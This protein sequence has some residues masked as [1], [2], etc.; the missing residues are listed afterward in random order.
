MLRGVREFLTVVQAVVPVFLVVIGGWLIRRV[1]WL[2]GEADAS[3]LR[4]TVNVLMPCLVF[5][6]I[7]GSRAFAHAGQVLFAV[8]TGFA[9]VL[10]GL[11]V[12]LLVQ[13]WV[14]AR[15]PSTR[16]TFAF[17]VAIY[18]YGYLPLPLALALFDRETVAVL[19][20]YNVG[21]EI[22]FWSFALLLLAG[23]GLR[24]NWRRFLNPP[25]LTIVGT[26]TLNAVGGD[27]WVPGVVRDATHLVGQCAI[28][29]GLLLIGAIMA[30]HVG[31][32]VSRQGGRVMV[33]S[34][35]LRLGLLPVAFL[36]MATVLPAGLE[37]QRVL[38][39]QAAMPAAVFS[40]V[41]ARHYGGDAATA[42]R[43]VLATS[44]LGLITIPLWLRFGIH[45]LG[46]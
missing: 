33:L 14:P 25:L 38:V 37:L 20:V 28:P 8:G 13:R 41:M 15:N 46:L 23:G 6:S 11:L 3:L 10:L 34:C 26:L 7:L 42:L 45:L 1:N 16:R 2:T 36:W 5:D 39:L 9:T 27:A 18:N 31:D 32:F 4:V 21:V 44:L 40:I 19:F 30:D 43:V 24:G 12:A 29:V 22:G 35:V 17:S